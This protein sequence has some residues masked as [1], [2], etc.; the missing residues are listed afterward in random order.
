MGRYATREI[1]LDELLRG[2][3]F[4]D[5]HRVV[6][7]SLIAS[8]ER[9]SIKDLEPF[10]GYERSQDLRE[11]S[12]SGRLVES[13]LAGGGLDTGDR[14]CRIVEDY[15]REDCESTL[16]LRDWL[17]GLRAEVLSRGHDVPRPLP[18]SGEA[19]E[20]VTATSTRS[21]GNSATNCSRTC[22]PIR[23][24][25]TTKSGHGSRWHT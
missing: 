25:G 23:W 16:R 15:N 10:F 7:R 11:A 4:V 14:H 2:N 21:C 5:L 12:Q 3:V 19:S 1:E 17:E 13:A 8:V 9:Y 20:A 6:K 22:P 24:I 18:A